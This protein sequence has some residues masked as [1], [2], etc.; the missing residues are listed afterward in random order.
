MVLRCELLDLPVKYIRFHNMVSWCDTRQTLGRPCRCVLIRGSFIKQTLWHLGLGISPN[1]WPC[2]QCCW[3]MSSPFRETLGSAAS[4]RFS[5]D[6]N[7]K[8]HSSRTGLLSLS[9][10][11]I[12]GWI[13]LR[14]GAVLCIVRCS[15][16]S[17]ATAHGVLWASSSSFRVVTTKNVSRFG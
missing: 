16:P 3:H 4:F 10:G 8:N 6:L 2:L 9:P 7:V 13:I 5:G 12:W 15:A 11:H 17:L 1:P 14:V